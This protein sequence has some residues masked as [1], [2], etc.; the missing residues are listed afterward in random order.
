MG[1]IYLET[2]DFRKDV[3]IGKGERY[4]Y[5]YR[6]NKCLVNEI[7]KNET[8]KIL[9]EKFGYNALEIKKICIIILE[10]KH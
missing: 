8:I 5:I 3:G 2:E 7:T 1:T 9:K 4:F 10:N 6:K